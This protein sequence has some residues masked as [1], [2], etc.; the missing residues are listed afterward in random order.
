MIFVLIGIAIAIGTGAAVL[1]WPY[2]IVAVLIGAPV[3][4]SVA[5]LLGAAVVA[6]R[7]PKDGH[8]P[9]GVAA[10]LGQL[11]GRRNQR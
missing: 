8:D 9:A 6:L 11:L 10:V 3:A 4:A 7:K 5:V 1:L 2:G